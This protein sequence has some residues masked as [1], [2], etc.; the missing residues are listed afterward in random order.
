MCCDVRR[1]E[2][3]ELER[4]Q[5]REGSLKHKTEVETLV[6]EHQAEVE[7]LRSGYESQVSSLQRQAAQLQQRLEDTEGKLAA[8]QVR[9]S[10][11]VCMLHAAAFRQQTP[12]CC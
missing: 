8:A 2:A 12:A 9:G 6:A 11:S 5:L 3:Y 1:Y 10:G 7:A 4:V